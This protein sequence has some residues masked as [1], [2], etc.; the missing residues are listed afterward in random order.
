MFFLLRAGDVSWGVIGVDNFHIY[1]GDEAGSGSSGGSSSG[2]SGGSSS[3]GGGGSGGGGSSKGG[4]GG[5]GSIVSKEGGRDG[6]K[7]VPSFVD[8]KEVLGWL[9]QM[10]KLFGN[11][12]YDTKEAKALRRIEMFAMQANVS[13][14]ALSQVTPLSPVLMY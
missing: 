13:A 6:D 4:G 5:G 2:G 7:G 3:G 10:G 11:A 9:Q 8:Q 14:L 1:R 12:A